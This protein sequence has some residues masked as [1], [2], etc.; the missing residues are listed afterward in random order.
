MTPGDQGIAAAKRDAHDHDHGS[1]LTAKRT[2]KFAE[3][4]SLAS[5]CLNCDLEYTYAK[6]HRGWVGLPCI[7][8][9]PEQRQAVTTAYITWADTA[10]LTAGLLK[11]LME[12]AR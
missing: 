7:D 8:R 6:D 4:G 3:H 2:H 11:R 12:A 1:C 10:R 5:P 9:T